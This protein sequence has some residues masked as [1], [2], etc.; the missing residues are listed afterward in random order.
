MPRDFFRVFAVLPFASFVAVNQGS[1]PSKD[2]GLPAVKWVKCICFWIESFQFALNP[3]WILKPVGCCLF[4]LEIKLP[5]IFRRKMFAKIRGK[6]FLLIW[7]VSHPL[8]DMTQSVSHDVPTISQI[9]CE[10]GGKKSQFGE[11]P[12]ILGY[13]AWGI[14]LAMEILYFGKGRGWWTWWTW[15]TMKLNRLDG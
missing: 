3:G 13:W 6:W 11:S 9:N 8:Q 4:Y 12:A 10:C 7:A 2:G 1:F 15:W 14:C 5:K